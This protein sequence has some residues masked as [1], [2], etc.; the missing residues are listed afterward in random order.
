MR[1]M[2]AVRKMPIITINLLEGRTPEEKKRL[3]KAITRDIEEILKV[4]SSETMIIFN[5]MSR[6]DY[7]KGGVQAS[8]WKK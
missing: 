5:D 2:F 1:W 4:P 7:A 3:V 6:V 8:E